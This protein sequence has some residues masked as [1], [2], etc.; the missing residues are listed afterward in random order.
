[1]TLWSQFCYKT[2]LFEAF[3]GFP[4][5]CPPLAL[6]CWAP[7]GPGCTSTAVEWLYW[8]FVCCLE[9]GTW[10]DRVL[11]HW[12][13]IKD[14]AGKSVCKSEPARS[15]A[16]PGYTHGCGWAP[17]CPQHS[18]GQP[19]TG[20][21]IPDPLLSVCKYHIQESVACVDT[22]AS[23]A[24]KLAPRTGRNFWGWWHPA[25]SPSH[26]VG[27]IKVPKGDVGSIIW[28]W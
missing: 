21:H 25:L 13:P 11:C 20:F 17:V 27:A 28:N 4:S 23:C 7:P 18:S 16:R 15:T 24:K 12:A 19:G 22:S 14:Q 9:Y 2:W 1:M 26:E 6:A 3:K 5:I 10:R 8:N